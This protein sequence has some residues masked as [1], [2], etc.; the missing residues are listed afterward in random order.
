MQHRCLKEMAAL[1]RDIGAGASRKQD[2]Q[3]LDEI[4][5]GMKTDFS[6][7]IPAGPVFGSDLSVN[8]LIPLA[9]LS[10][11]R[12]AYRIEILIVFSSAIRFDCS[13]RSRSEEGRVPRYTRA[14]M[15]R[16]FAARSL[17]WCS[18]PRRRARFYCS[19]AYFTFVGDSCGQRCFQ[20]YEW[21]GVALRMTL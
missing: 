6:H 14:T 7:P 21:P 13:R 18:H 5:P 16:R 15:A 20:H 19:C 11:L 9:N 4:S 10:A 8:S 2:R 12:S 1:L 3:G 17:L